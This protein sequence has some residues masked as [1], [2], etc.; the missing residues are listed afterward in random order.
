MI[1][2]PIGSRHSAT[3][4]GEAERHLT[5]E[6]C[7]KEF[8]YVHKRAVT[9]SAFN[10]LDACTDR[11][12]NDRAKRR[13][14]HRLSI[15]LE[16]EDDFVACPTCG[17]YQ[18]RMIG[19]KKRRRFR[20]VLRVLGVCFIPTYLVVN[21]LLD[22]GAISTLG[23]FAGLAIA[24]LLFIWGVIELWNPNDSATSDELAARARSSEGIP[25]V[26][27]REAKAIQA[28]L[29]PSEHSYPASN[30]QTVSETAPRDTS[31][32][33]DFLQ[34][35][36][37]IKKQ[38]EWKA[39][40]VAKQY[41]RRPPWLAMIAVS[42]GAGL[43][44]ILDLLLFDAGVGDPGVRIVGAPLFGLFMGFWAHFLSSATIESQLVPNKTLV[45]DGSLSDDSTIPIRPQ[46]LANGV[47]IATAAV[48][49][50]IC[51]TGFQWG[52]IWVFFLVFLCQTAL[53]VPL[54][55]IAISR[56][57]PTGSVTAATSTASA[58]SRPSS[59]KEGSG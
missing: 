52:T 53:L 54:C 51:A 45:H 18:S 44:A 59:A 23:I 9:G 30:S 2:I 8:V 17:R 4:Q 11:F 31:D 40:G 49:S 32:A 20:N 34:A 48:A 41:W 38:D 56:T 29:I 50:G 21:F 15:A 28:L 55:L 22:A 47:A 13:A 3:V 57:R 25:I 58:S 27:F 5:C 1:P 14:A 43:G 7:G 19:D 26:Q 24:V 36:P 46:Y 12:M 37:R 42:A 35:V 6:A 39:Q 16:K 10:F 33:L